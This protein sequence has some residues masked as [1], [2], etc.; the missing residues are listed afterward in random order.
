MR[1]KRYKACLA[2]LRQVFGVPGFR[3]GQKAAVN[4]LLSG[5][6][7]LCI[8]PTGA[9]KSLCWQL[10]AVMRPGLTV[11][12][13]PLI[14]LM[15]DQVQSLKRRGV[16]AA[17]LNSLMTRQELA[18][19]EKQ[20]RTGTV[21]ILLVSPERLETAGFLSL[22]TACPP[23]L[24]VVDEAHCVVQWGGEFR[25]P[26]SRIGAF[27]EQLPRRPVVCA[28]TATADRDMQREIC[29]SL[30]LRRPRR[31]MMPVMRENLRYSVRTTTDRT[32][33]ILRILHSDPSR[34]VIFCRSRA[35]TE[36]LAAVL[37]REGY[38]AEYYHAGLTREERLKAQERFRSGATACLA[39]TTAFGMGVDIP[40]VRR[41]I[42][43]SLPDTVIDLVQQSGRAGRDL[44]PADCV[45]LIAPED[46]MRSGRVLHAMHASTRLAPLRRSALMRAHWRPLRTL[47]NACLTRRCIPAALSEAFGQRSR[48]CGCCSACTDGP[49]LRRVPRLPAMDA[50]SLRLWLL[51]WQR[52]AIAEKLGVPPDRIITRGALREAARSMTL[53]P[54]RQPQARQA[55]Q[56]LLQTIVRASV[57]QPEQG[58]AQHGP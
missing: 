47:L 49:L 22:C 10:P 56:R 21:R 1:W 5:R 7:V 53:P 40:D 16:P 32:G 54:I 25:P 26:Y 48:P 12:V 2:V 58:S 6:D 20:V 50:A 34:T 46:L 38:A 35:R 31:V 29:D 43:D 42:H 37:R 8:L 4:A 13:S 44:L 39:A 15:D 19:A 33:E 9:G 41:V 55:M 57:R 36:Q 23:Q 28:M 11:V 24:L 52:E 51:M 27:M 18:D 17:T 3:P 30:A 14:A 45:I